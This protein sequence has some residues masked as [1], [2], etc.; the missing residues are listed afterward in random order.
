MPTLYYSPGACSLA[1]HIVLE[2]IGKPFDTVEVNVRR[3]DQLKPEYLAINPRGRV[4][5][6][7]IGAF[8]LTE[9]P[10]ILSYLD[11]LH[12]DAALMPEDPALEARGLSLMSWLASSVHIDFAQVFRPARY[13]DDEAAHPGVIASGKAAVQHHYDEI[14]ELLAESPYALGR[15]YSVLDPYLL[16]F[17]RWGYRLQLDMTRWPR[18]DAH[19]RRVAERPASQ[20]VFAREGIALVP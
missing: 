18:Y 2:E 4:P 9:C 14:E 12:P 11:R 16:V 7:K 19:A 6:L 3:G 15:K 8:T 10:A 20:R 5:T 17:Y 1:S 13:T